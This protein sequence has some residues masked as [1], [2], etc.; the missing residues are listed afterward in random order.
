MLQEVQLCKQIEVGMGAT[1]CSD[2]I[3]SRQDMEPAGIDQH[4][5]A[6]VDSP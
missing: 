5:S 1:N 6:A 2:A 4:D 3:K